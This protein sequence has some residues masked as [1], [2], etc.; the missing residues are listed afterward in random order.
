MNIRKLM[1]I[2]FL[3]VCSWAS[4]QERTAGDALLLA[5][6]FV[7]EKFG[8]ALTKGK[9]E[10]LTTCLNDSTSGC[11]IFNV[12][13]NNG[14]VIVSRSTSAYP[15]LAFSD[16]GS[17]RKSS[18]PPNMSEWLEEYDRQQAWFA[19]Q[20]ADAEND[21]TYDWT[22]IAPMLTTEWGQRA[23]YNLML[24]L[25]PVQNDTE[26]RVHAAAGC[27]TTA[28]CQVMYF[29]QWPKST[30]KPIPY[31]MNKYLTN[32]YSVELDDLPVTD[33]DW[34]KMCDTYSEN[35]TSE[36]A[37]EVA[38][39]MRYVSQAVPIFYTPTESPG[40]FNKAT[41]VDYFGYDDSLTMLNLSRSYDEWEEYVYAELSEGRPVL[42]SGGPHA[43]V[44]DGYQADGFFHFNWGW[45]GWANGYYRT[46]AMILTLR[47]GRCYNFGEFNDLLIGIR[48]SENG[49]EASITQTDMPI[50]TTESYIDLTGRRLAHPNNRGLYIKN[51]E[52]YI[53]R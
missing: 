49:E 40:R 13:Q 24:P 5:Q 4:A 33:F 35:D 17:L 32:K 25:L 31:E 12:E 47:D 34:E 48:P 45:D 46:T 42:T 11:Y 8:V 19:A 29:H 9:G 22:D 30:D 52:K 21:K 26:T 10:K 51:G 7:D 20:D 3:S 18:M 53:S 23:P 28:L 2:T 27:V 1:L 41:L 6:Q 37:L 43:F 44:C 38:K 14:W 16:R 39:L 50:S 15:V 36:S